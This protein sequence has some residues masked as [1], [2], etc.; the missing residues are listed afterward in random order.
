MT[1][2]GKVDQIVLQLRAQLQRAARNRT[3]S[4]IRSDQATGSPLQRFKAVERTEG[5]AGG[6]L[7]RKFVRA[8]LTE[9]LGEDLANL[10]EFERISNEVWNLIEQ[11]DALR[12][13]V[14]Q[15]LQQLGEG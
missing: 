11:D 1:G 7:R 14:E 9:E 2:I 6:D 12:S 10:P 5:Y 8:L 13:D 3:R 4:S 15:A